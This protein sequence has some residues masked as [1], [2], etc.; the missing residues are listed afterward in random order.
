WRQRETYVPVQ[1]DPPPLAS[2]L[3]A[4]ADKPTDID[5][6]SVLAHRFDLLGSGPRVVAAMGHGE[7]LSPGNQQRAAAIRA[8]I[9]ADYSAIDWQV[10]FKS[11]YRWRADRLSSS[12]IYG[13]R[14]GVDV[15]LPW[16]LARCQHL[17]WLAY[18]N[19]VAEFRN[20]VLDFAAANP[21]GYGVNWMCTMDVAIRAANMLLADDLLEAELDAPFRAEF[22][23]LI[24]AHGRHIFANLESQGANHYLANVV[25]L[26]FIAAY[27]SPDE[28]SEK[29]LTFASDE[30]VTQID[31]QFSAD[32]A[33][34]EASTSYHQLSAEMAI[35]GTALLLGQ[36]KS[37]A[38]P[39]S[40]MEKLQRMAEFSMHATKSN[41]RVVQIG[42]ND[43]GHFFTLTVPVDLDHRA[44]VGAIN[45]L[46]ERDDL[47]RFCGKDQDFNGRVVSALAAG[48]TLPGG[49]PTPVVYS[50][51]SEPV[52]LNLTGD[53]KIVP[54]DA[55][56][57]QDLEAF[58]YPDFG[59][60]GW[61]SERFFLS[62]RCGPIGQD[63]NGG[64]AHND[65]LAV[66]L[67]IDGEDWIA[68]PGTG[69]YTAAPKI[70]DAYR[71]ARAHFVPA[72]GTGEPASLSLGLFRLEDR[73]RARCLAFSKDGFEGTH[74]GYGRPLHRRIKIID[75]HIRITDGFSGDPGQGMVVQAFSDG[76]S[77]RKYLGL[78]LRFSS[79]YG[80]Y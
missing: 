79:G 6:Q 31:R 45:G 80:L 35:F 59:L 37:G 47:A 74:Q 68:D 30:F 72:G 19:Q 32:G 25:G 5:C 11:G 75:D 16:E 2:L 44:L 27:L 71:S 14:P 26:L 57:L 18:G 78:T 10:D 38:L 66:E 53:I 1:A 41:G 50:G 39:L 69:V 23:A 36:G 54:P 9:D 65:A 28:E 67:N 34:F 8:L 15:K 22:Q 20:Q 52:D 63:G 62:V 70:R 13:Q 17:P 61:R 3:G 4:L 24:V 43:S 51:P 73:A 46:F 77:L 42:D 49:R 40:H 76:Q 29:W 21:P 64:H 48:V 56:V 7:P 60:Y 55:S 33:N 12:L 58:S